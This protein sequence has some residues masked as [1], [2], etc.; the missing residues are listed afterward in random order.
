MLQ[1]VDVG[2]TQLHTSAEFGP[3][4]IRWKRQVKKGFKLQQVK[5]LSHGND[6]TEL[7]P[8]SDDIFIVSYP[9][10]GQTWIRFLLANLIRYEEAAASLAAELQ[11]GGE[12]SPTAVTSAQT[13]A[14]ADPIDF[15]TVESRIPFLEDGREEW[16]AWGFKAAP[17]PRI[18]KSH[19]PILSPPARYPCNKR[20]TESN[21][22]APEHIGT[23]HWW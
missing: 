16:I 3:E 7:W 5:A 20:L 17:I 21:V 9:K 10:S 8:R 18:F 22:T 6:D 14:A 11:D 12:R 4:P 1:P 19:Q 15:D 23:H 2:G 13:A